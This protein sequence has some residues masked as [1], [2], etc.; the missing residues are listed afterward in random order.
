MED[1]DDLYI[2]LMDGPTV[3]A[4]ADSPSSLGDSMMLQ[5]FE[6]LIHI[7][8][9]VKEIKEEMEEKEDEG[10]GGMEFPG[11]FAGSPLLEGEFY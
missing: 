2:G 9:C 11:I 6:K 10:G 3:S 5:M 7:E 8:H 1:M 4:H